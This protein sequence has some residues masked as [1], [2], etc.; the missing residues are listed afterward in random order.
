MWRPHGK[1]GRGEGVKIIEPKLARLVFIRL[2]SR[3][4]IINNMFILERFHGEVDGEGR[5]VLFSGI[6]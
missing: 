4:I 5:G 2:P 3:P 1:G 6:L